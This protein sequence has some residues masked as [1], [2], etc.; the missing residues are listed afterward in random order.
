MA[1]ALGLAAAEHFFFTW[2]LFMA[3]RVLRNRTVLVGATVLSLVRALLAFPIHCGTALIIGVA[4]AKKIVLKENVRIAPAFAMAIFVH[5]TFDAVSMV[6][7]GLATVKAIRPSIWSG[8]GVLVADIIMT[9]GLML[10]C[11]ASYK[12]LVRSDGYASLN[13]DGNV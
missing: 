13:G 3:S 12:S 4:M 6:V 10:Y 1:G 8:V 11:R 2:P 9:V 7:S 5:G